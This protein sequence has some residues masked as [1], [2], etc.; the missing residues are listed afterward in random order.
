VIACPLRDVDL[1]RPERGAD[2]LEHQQRIGARLIGGA[3]GVVSVQ[4]R[5]LIVLL[6]VPVREEHGDQTERIE[7]GDR[8]LPRPSV[9][10]RPTLR[11]SSS[12]IGVPSNF[13]STA[14]HSKSA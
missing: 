7:L 6:V 9:P 3:W 10:P 11:R 1:H 14:T 13:R 2:V 12:S 8:R 4:T 5:P